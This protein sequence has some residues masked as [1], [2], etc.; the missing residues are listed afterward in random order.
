LTASWRLHV[1]TAYWGADPTEWQ[2]AEYSSAPP[3]QNRDLI[4]EAMLGANPRVTPPRIAFTTRR[5]GKRKA[6]GGWI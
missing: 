2:W 6:T 1:P 3:E 5:P 4:R